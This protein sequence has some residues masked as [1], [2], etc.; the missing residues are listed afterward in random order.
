[1]TH[2]NRANLEP[3]GPSEPPSLHS[4]AMEDLRYIR[5]TMERASAFTA[6]PGWGGVAMGVSALVAAAI[7]VRL[8][9][10]GWLA[11]WI[12][13]AALAVA[14]GGLAMAHKARTARVPLFGGPGRKFVLSL[15][16]P[17][18]A[19]L[20][21]TLALVQNGQMEPLPGIWM[22]CYG[23]AVV[24]GGAFSVPIVTVM[25]VCFMAAGGLALFFPLWGDALMAM[26]FGGLHLLF[27][28][29]IARRYGG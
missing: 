5:E 3:A 8:T 18:V 26:T 13:E 12:G 14:I 27:G 22:L 29:I 23:A 2:A 15:F 20:L 9:P 10:W 4:R 17:M 11:V 7:A 21:L 16:P 28:V 24:T 1:M 25:G 6:V 19:G